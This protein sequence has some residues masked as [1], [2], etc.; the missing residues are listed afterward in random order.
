MDTYPTW[1]DTPPT[2][3]MTSGAGGSYV[4]ARHLYAQLGEHNPHT[5]ATFRGMFHGCLDV[6][7]VELYL[8]FPPGS[9]FLNGPSHVVRPRLVIDGVEVYREPAI[10][11]PLII[12]EPNPRDSNTRR[13]RMAFAGIDAALRARPDLDPQGP[14]TIEL[15]ISPQFNSSDTTVYRYDTVEQPSGIAFNLDGHELVEGGY[16]VIEPTL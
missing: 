14:H 6:M 7:A 1:T 11:G 9:V 12:T 16:V 2:Q 4:V 13:F 8:T 15:N 5:G 3:S 10:V